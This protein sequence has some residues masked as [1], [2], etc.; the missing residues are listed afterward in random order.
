[1][2]SL[3]QLQAENERLL[4][5]LNGF[6]LIAEELVIK[7]VSEHFG[8]DRRSERD[9]LIDAVA[10]AVERAVNPTSSN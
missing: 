6:A 7:A 3:E 9:Q 5:R 8:A 4:A 2:R 10:L 1:M